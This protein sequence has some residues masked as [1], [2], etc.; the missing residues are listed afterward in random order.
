MK[1]SEKKEEP[2]E[3]RTIDMYDK[4]PGLSPTKVKLDDLIVFTSSK[5]EDSDK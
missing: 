5:K 1:L 2:S 4:A 3:D